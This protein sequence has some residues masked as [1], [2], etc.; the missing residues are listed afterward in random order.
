MKLFHQEFGSNMTGGSSR[1]P[2]GGVPIT[3]SHLEAKTRTVDL[4]IFQRM[5]ML[6]NGLLVIV[7]RHITS[8]VKE[9]FK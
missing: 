6:G 3:T 5:C 8:F 4:L 9:F 1:G 2:R 7:Q